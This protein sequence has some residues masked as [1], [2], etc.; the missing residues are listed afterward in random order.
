AVLGQAPAQRRG[1]GCELEGRRIGGLHPAHDGRDQ[2]LEHPAA[3]PP[4]HH[5]GH[6][7]PVAGAERGRQEALDARAQRPD[8]AQHRA[9]VRCEGMPGDPEHAR[10]GGGVDTGVGDHAAA[11]ALARGDD[12]L[13][14]A[15]LGDQRVDGPGAGRLRLGTGVQREGPGLRQGG[16]G[17]RAAHGPR[18]LQQHHPAPCALVAACG[19]QSGQAAADHEDPGAHAGRTPCAGETA[20]WRKATRSVRTCGSAVGG[21]PWPRLTTWPLAAAPASS[22]A[23]ASAKRARSEVNSTAGSM[24][25]WI[26]VPSGSTARAWSSR[27]RW[28]TP[29]AVAPAACICGSRWEAPTPKCRRGTCRSATWPRAAAE[30]DRTWATYCSALSA[31]TQESNSWT[32]EAPASTWARRKRPDSSATQAA[33][34]AQA[35]GSVRISAR[36]RRWSR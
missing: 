10:A 32:A 27:S 8:G 26:G 12:P 5:L 20:S 16:L 17:D 15:Q 35:S 21:T 11:Q 4:T 23:V 34:R 30:W 14:Q 9:D 28:S 3:Q 25:P 2:L 24:L 22:T 18:R 1:G 36:V 29:I 19:E 6:G 7:G 33:R 31:P 13:L